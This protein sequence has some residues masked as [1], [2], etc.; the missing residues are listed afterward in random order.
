MT[1]LLRAALLR[2]RLRTTSTVAAMALAVA[3]VCVLQAI[4]RELAAFMDDLLSERRF[5]VTHRAGLA[6]GLP[7][8]VVRRLR[9]LPGSPAALA[10]TYVGGSVES[11]G[12]VT[13]PSLAVDAEWVGRVYPDYELRAEQLGAFLRHRDGALVGEQ[14]MRRYGWTIGDRATLRSAFWGVDLELEIVGT[15][16]AQPTLWLQQSHLEEALRA[17]GGDGLPWNTIVWLR[18][19]DAPLAETSGGDGPSD[20]GLRAGVES[21]GREMG[22]PL[23]LQGERSFF[24]RLLADARGF[25]RLLEV[26][27][28]LV[29]AC[30]GVVAS[31]S[32][33]IGVRDRSRELATL[34]ALGW[35]RS[36]LFALVLEESGLIGLAGGLVGVAGAFGLVAAARA[37][38]APDVPLGMVASV[39]IDAGTAL[40]AI[41]VTVVLG[42]LAGVLPALGA[43]RRPSASL[44]R[45]A[46]A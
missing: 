24:S 25:A 17:R 7:T 6:Y 28:V 36:R 19:A 30:V 21:I 41:F 43:V 2:N 14:T 10:S 45:E 42:T 5:S 13:F 34:R 31:S 40:V 12:R 44:L 16:P 1:R 37:I 23:T 8:T 46:A 32:I 18:L 9:A 27:I 35:S 15:L 22:V 39:R 33:A 11:D 38:D 20:D 29:A 26:V 4:P 3:L